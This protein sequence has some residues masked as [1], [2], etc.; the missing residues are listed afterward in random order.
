M[1]VGKNIAKQY[2]KAAR[3]SERVNGRIDA[4]ER[5]MELAQSRTTDQIPEFN[6]LMFPER[7]KHP[8]ALIGALAA[9][10]T[11]NVILPVCPPVPVNA[12][13]FRPSISSE[14]SAGIRAAN[15]LVGA[16]S[17][18]I[19]KKVTALVLVADTETDLEPVME[20]AGGSEKYLDVCSE[21]S[22]M[23][24]AELAVGVFVETFSTHFGFNGSE[25]LYHRLQYEAEDNL[26]S[27]MRDDEYFAAKIENISQSRAEKHTLILGR[28]EQSHELAIRYAGQYAALGDYVRRTEDIDAVCNYPTPNNEFYNYQKD[29]IVPLFESRVEQK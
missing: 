15:T 8:A 17:E 1:L 16:F 9:K 10:D 26:R 19:C 13:T 11:L 27:L 12:K 14:A 5:M 4:V 23:I 6:G 3:F 18:R 29:S 20:R 22:G 28:P 25:L 24:A 7:K 21:T 2:A